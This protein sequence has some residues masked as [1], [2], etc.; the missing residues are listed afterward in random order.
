MIGKSHTFTENS[1]HQVGTVRRKQNDILHHQRIECG[2]QH[3]SYAG[4]LRAWPL[5]RPCVQMSHWEQKTTLAQNGTVLIPDWAPEP[6]MQRSAGG[7][8]LRDQTPVVQVK[9]LN[10][11]SRRLNE[12]WHHSSVTIMEL[13]VLIYHHWNTII[14]LFHFE[15]SFYCS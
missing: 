8:R 10:H 11:H 6:C 14:V 9:L 5:P 13:W 2:V 1:F 3:R 12:Q 7:P 15:F 4:D